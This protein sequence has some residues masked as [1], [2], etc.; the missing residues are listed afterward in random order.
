MGLRHGSQRAD[1]GP[2]W[3]VHLQPLFPTPT[4]SQFSPVDG[5]ELRPPSLVAGAYPPCSAFK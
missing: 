3:F 1:A 5:T 4:L 2:A